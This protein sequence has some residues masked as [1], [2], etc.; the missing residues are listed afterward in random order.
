MSTQTLDIDSGNQKGHTATKFA[1]KFMEDA[2]LF[3]LAKKDDQY[4]EASNPGRMWSLPIPDKVTEI[5]E[6]MQEFHADDEIEKGYF[7]IQ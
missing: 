3:Y 1:K 7:S 5:L 2:V 4:V 6:M